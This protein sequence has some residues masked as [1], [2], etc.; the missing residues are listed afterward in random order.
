MTSLGNISSTKEEIFNE[1]SNFISACYGVKNQCDL[2]KVK[3]VIWRRKAEGKLTPKLSALP[4]TTEVFHLN[5][6][7][8]HYQACIWNHCMV[9]DPPK[10]NP[11]QCGWEKD[12][13]NE[14]LDPM[15][16]PGGV[17][18]APQAA[19]KR[20]SCTCISERTYTRCSCTASQLSYSEYCSC[21]EEC[22][23]RGT[24]KQTVNDDI[25][26]D[27]EVMT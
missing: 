6:L 8:A 15:M 11:C 9:P 19:L 7:R 1:S 16:F 25:S 2:S 18:P 5:I 4:P 24:A 20:F 26:D 27:E 22:S 21:F 3:Y 17:S 23:N 10:L 14:C 13:S 12:E